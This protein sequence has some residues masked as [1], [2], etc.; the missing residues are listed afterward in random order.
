M[1]SNALKSSQPIAALIYDK[2]CMVLTDVKVLKRWTEYWDGLYSYEVQP[3]IS[4]MQTDEYPR[5]GKY[6][7]PILKK[8]VEA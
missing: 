3:Y 8:A 1:D 7:L 4:L 2:D 6:S 5:E